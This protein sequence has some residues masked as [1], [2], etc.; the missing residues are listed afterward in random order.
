MSSSSNT[1][2]QT[3][4]F[5]GCGGGYDIFGC[6]PLLYENLQHRVIITNLSFSNSEMIGELSTK[7]PEKIA[8]IGRN[9]YKIFPNSCADGVHYFPENLMANQ[10]N[11][12]VYAMRDY[13]TVEE[14]MEFYHALFEEEKIDRIDKFYLVDGGCDVLLDGTETELATYVEDMM[15]LKS[16]VNLMKSGRMKIE[17]FMVCAIGINVDCGHDVKEDE[18][19]NR[20]KVLENSGIVISKELLSLDEPRTQ[21]YKNIVLKCKTEHTL[22]HSFVLYALEGIYGYVIPKFDTG[23]KITENTK[24]NVS[25]LTRTYLICDG[26]KLAS[27]IT[28]LHKIDLKTTSEEVRS[29][30]P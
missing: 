11:L 30:F 1:D 4:L 10:L 20:I 14:T 8:Q 16:I 7:Y 9:S 28:Y 12:P 2:K 23:A 18:L 21:F 24:V 13:G 27:S 3:I 17:H 6:L 5:A 22:V 26:L 15:H 19:I 29:F 25:D